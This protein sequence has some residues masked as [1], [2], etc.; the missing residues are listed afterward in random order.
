MPN[1]NPETCLLCRFKKQCQYRD[2]EGANL[3]FLIATED[4]GCQKFGPEA[5]LV[6]EDQ[7]AENS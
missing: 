1:V 4:G 6:E 3:S 5:E 7:K 2:N